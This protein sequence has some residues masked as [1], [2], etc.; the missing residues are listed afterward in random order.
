MCVSE[1]IA[2]CHNS[3]G[4][5][6]GVP[7]PLALQ[8]HTT[9]RGQ[10]PCVV[11]PPS[12]AAALLCNSPLVKCI[13]WLSQ[14][15]LMPCE[16]TSIW[17]SL[18]MTVGGV[19]AGTGRWV[20]RCSTLAP[21]C[22]SA[23]LHG[24]CACRVLKQEERKR[25]LSLFNLRMHARFG[26]LRFECCSFR[27]QHHQAEAVELFQ[28]L[29]AAATLR[30]TGKTS[31]HSLSLNFLTKATRSKSSAFDQPLLLDSRVRCVSSTYILLIG[32]EVSFARVP[33]TARGSSGR[34][35]CYAQCIFGHLRYYQLY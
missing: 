30:H 3:Q 31:R 18:P 10:T 28:K 23:W 4:G 35:A 2:T 14:R 25:Q 12:R 22:R 34:R 7:Y 27:A 1:H 24:N 6:A 19:R 32:A 17:I 29:C 20:S 9:D 33:W 15:T 16:C 11:Q 21:G 26:F 5:A 8:H 13:P